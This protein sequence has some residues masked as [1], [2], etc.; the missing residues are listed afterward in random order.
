MSL[1]HI[2]C[3]PLSHMHDYEDLHWS[4][5]AAGFISKSDLLIMTDL[6]TELVK[7][8]LFSWGPL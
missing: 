7:F 2:Q 4:Y 3:V 1:S 8:N 5:F 6:K